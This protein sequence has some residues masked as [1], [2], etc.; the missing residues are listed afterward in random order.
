MRIRG[1]V[2]PGQCGL[3]D[4][5]LST[6]KSKTVYKKGSD[7][8]TFY[9]SAEMLQSSISKLLVYNSL[10]SKLTKIPFAE[11][12]LAK[13]DIYAV[14]GNDLIVFLD[15]LEEAL[16]S[17][18]SFF[19]LQGDTNNHGFPPEMYTY[20]QKECKKLQPIY[21]ESKDFQRFSGNTLLSLLNTI[22]IDVRR[23]ESAYVAWLYSSEILML[24][25]DVC[26]NSESKGIDSILNG[27]F[28][29]EEH[30]ESSYLLQLLSNEKAEIERIR[31]VRNSLAYHQKTL[32]RLSSYIWNVMQYQRET[33]SSEAKI[34]CGKTPTFPL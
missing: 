22:R 10:V 16:H 31:K 33:I 26:S 4:K 14:K 9:T 3:G 34:W 28:V 18:Q 29:I 23:L 24:Y 30:E 8:T 7:I 6:L 12:A 13:Y 15:W 27:S 5:G 17:F 19:Y 32:N 1:N 20:I 21:G 25:G 11:K 2:C